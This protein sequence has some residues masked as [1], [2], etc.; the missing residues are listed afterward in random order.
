VGQ[1]VKGSQNIV[2][3]KQNLAKAEEDIEKME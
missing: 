2:G 3:Y 1:H